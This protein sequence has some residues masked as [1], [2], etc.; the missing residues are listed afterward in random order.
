MSS[1][2]P[3]PVAARGLAVF[4][5]P[6][7]SK[8]AAL[9]WHR[10][11]TS[12]PAVLARSW[13]PGANVGVACRASNVAGLDLDRHDGK[14][15]GIATFEVL[16]ADL[17]QP[18]PVTLTVA[19]PHGGLHLYFRVPAGRIVPSVA[20]RWPGVD[21]RGPGRRLGGYLAGPG[22]VVDGAPYVIERDTAIAGLPPWLAGLLEAR[23]QPG[24]WATSSR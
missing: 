24:A 19:T 23:A 2:D 18:W 5:L 22:S 10:A 20:G 8:H 15:D 9:G 6:P 21:V 7:G 12:D 4:P 14:A 3:F 1:P 17:G 16:C 11:C 13:V